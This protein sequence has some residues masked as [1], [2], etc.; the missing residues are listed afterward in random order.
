MRQTLK[1]LEEQLKNCLFPEQ[2]RFRQRLIR[3]K[4]SSTPKTLAKL[5]HDIERSIK[6]RQSRLQHLPTPDYP[7]NLPVSERR[8]EIITAIK[9]NQVVIICGETGSGKTTQLPKMCLELGLGLNGYIG[10]TQPRR[11]AAQSVAKRIAE[12]LKSEQAAG[13][14]IRFHDKTHANSYI[15]V[16]TDGILLAEVQEDR[17]LTQYD[18]LIIDEAHERS[19]NIDFL[20]GYLKWLLPRRKDLKLIITSATID[21]EK[22]SK[23]FNDAPIIEVSGRTYPV[24][25]RYRPLVS[26]T[27]E[28]DDRDIFQ[29]IVD[30]VDELK[31]ESRGDILIFFSGEREIRDA[32]DMLRKQNYAATE[33]LPLF[34]R[35]SSQEQYRI[36][37]A[38][39]GQRIIL[40]TNVAE[41][42][43]T[44]PG[45]KY[46]IDT[47]QVRISRYSWRARIQRLP[48]ERTSQASANQ[49]SGRCGRTSDG[50]AIRLY[51][52]EDFLARPAFTD[53]E[54]LRTN[55]ASV[56]LQMTHMRLGDIAAFPFIEPPDSRQIKDGFKLLFEIHAVDKHHRL[57]KM[58]RQIARMP[59]DPRLA[60]MLIEATTLKSLEA[61]LIIVS[62]LSI[63][64]PRERP[65][66]KQ[67]AADEKHSRFKDKHSDFIGYI[68]LW[69]YF[70]E[71]RAT[72][73]QNKLRKLCKKE[74]ISYIRMR[75]WQDIRDQIARQLDSTLAKDWNV[76]EDAIHKSLLTGLLGNI[77]FKDED[78]IYLGA[79]QKKFTLFPGSVL[80]KKP[81]KWILA[82]ELVETSKLFARTVARI[83]PE[84]IEHSAKHLIKRHYSE[85]H[86]EKR[87]AQVG[88]FERI[89]LY[90]ITLHARR[91]I[92][93]GP[94]DPK[95]S[96]ELFI[97]HALIYGEYET[98]ATFFQHN[99]KLIRSIENLEAK[100]RRRDILVDEEV[101]YDFY[102]R[103]IPAT[104]YNGK[105][106]E[107]WRKSQEKQHADALFYKAEDL[108]QRD[109]KHIGSAAFPDQLKYSGVSLPLQY[110]FEPGH[111]HDG[112]TCSVPHI[113]L[114]HIQPTLFD[115]L[116]PGMLEEK[117]T[118]I[119]R[120]LPKQTRKQFVPAPEYAKAC[121]EAIHSS[122][123]DS[124]FSTL[125]H[126]LLRMTGS[127]IPQEEWD[128]LKLPEHLVMRFEIID[129]KGKTLKT[130][131]DL[132]KLKGDVKHKTVESFQKIK[133]HAL[134]QQGL[135]NWTFGDLPEY[136]S[137]NNHG[138]H[139]RAYP[140][141][142]AKKDVV[143]IQLFDSLLESQ[144]AHKKGVRKL[145]QLRTTEQLRQL[146][147]H[148]SQ[149]QKLCMW[150]SATGKCDELQR[151]LVDASYDHT[152]LREA[153]PR[154][155][156]D[157]QELL[158]SRQNS[159]LDTS[160]TLCHLLD[161]VLAS[162]F[163]IHKQLKGNIKINWLEALNDMKKQM[164]HLI[165]PGFLESLDL[166][167]LRM[168][169]KYLKGVLRR[170]DKLQE[171]ETRDR[172]LRL[173]V[174][175]LWE[176]YT[177]EI[178]K[179]ADIQMLSEKDLTIYRWMIEEFRISLFAQELGTQRPISAK[180][181]NKFWQ[182]HST[183]R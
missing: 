112:V 48:I 51:S 174:L 50:I 33:I 163:E 88:A 81:P 12:E 92:N 56:I 7:E 143:D 169:P 120:A 121:V 87:S 126:Q 30:A 82:A 173:Q 150:Y 134:E 85:P 20:L 25:I 90:G 65:L 127:T 135:S 42:S 106:F 183:Q 94:I 102:D 55:L 93:Y 80:H 22:F 97:R 17:F 155:Q 103:I 159:L 76:N 109:T 167:Q 128:K 10:H 52:E 141:I 29:G 119:I 32:A 131:R 34:A 96:R 123:T 118:N 1:Q 24:E 133:T 148:I 101:L 67:Q 145:F 19:L 21:P 60:R 105:T 98:K 13:Y 89:T 72:L 129:E 179:N 138:I 4:K 122:S 75:E 172:G 18:T 26:E 43:L 149:Q 142:V 116:V 104:I 117:I 14:K 37:Q 111:D 86:W 44:V 91:K 69:N 181:L 137:V 130:G 132:L 8:E 46:V 140:A 147:K 77:G 136:L 170:L 70:Q 49:R 166:E 39:R 180:R 54:I 115:Y 113:L 57:S 168:L 164:Q 5:Q 59:I 108:F 6:T 107:K 99:R 68:N 16:M 182:E 153:L 41:T 160:K 114:S 66:E 177:V 100:S 152:F 58:G 161:P 64:D 144:T 125:N 47:G 27:E 156:T 71:Q 53:P 11:L 3:E 124:L 28:Q 176:R 62:A 79:H 63:Q 61:V 171:S 178:K 15:K 165:Y 83:Q 157:F 23:H 110:H 31:R 151:A 2:F 73:S 9:E 45:I 84:W 154:T 175:P 146:K 36:F 35:L 74:F 38:H 162:H 40:S 158:T 78:R 139:V 95:N